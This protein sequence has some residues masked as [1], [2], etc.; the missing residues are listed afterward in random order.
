MIRRTLISETRDKEKPPTPALAFPASHSESKPFQCSSKASEQ[1]SK[2][3][4]GAV[5]IPNFDNFAPSG[6]VVASAIM[7]FS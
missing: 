1:T 7:Q 2:L 4:A 3:L 6:S 5:E